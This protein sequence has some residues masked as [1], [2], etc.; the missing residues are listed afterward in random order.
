MIL[1]NL[2]RDQVDAALGD[3]IRINNKYMNLDKTIY[4]S[5]NSTFHDVFPHDIWNFIIEQTTYLTKIP[6]SS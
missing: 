3:M 6:G 4:T 5:R 1:P 2:A